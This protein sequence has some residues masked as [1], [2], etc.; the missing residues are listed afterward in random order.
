MYVF[1]KVADFVRH[2]AE[3]DATPVEAE[4][5]RIGLWRGVF[6]NVT[7]LQGKRT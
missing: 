7:W 4:I 1:G 3:H 6:G 2:A 5:V